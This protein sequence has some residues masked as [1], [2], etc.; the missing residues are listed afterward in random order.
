MLE[1]TARTP[2]STAPSTHGI[3]QVS[4]VDTA[5]PAATPT[6][7]DVALAYGAAGRSVLPI[8][9]GSKIPS[10]FNTTTGEFQELSWKKFQKRPAD[11]GMIQIMFTHSPLGIGIVCGP[12]S[13]VQIDGVQY[14]LEVTDFDDAEILDQFIEAANWQGLGELLRRLLH[15]RTPGGAG[16][17][18]YLC[19]QWAGNTKLAQRQEGVDEHGNP[20][21]VTL[22]ET[23][24]AGGQVV[25]APTPPGIHPEHP[26]RGYELVRGSWED[27]RIITPEERLVLF[28]LA[29]SFNEYVTPNQVHTTRDAGSPSTNGE[30]PGDTLNTTA[31]RDW[32]RN[33][34]ERHGWTLVR[35]RGDIQYWR[36]PGKD[37]K[38]W[39]ATLGACGPYF[40]VFSS[41]APPFEP[42]RGYLPFSAYTLLE[43]G[44]NFKAAAKALAPP[45]L[46]VSP[47]NSNSTTQAT[48]P[49]GDPAASLGTVSPCTHVANATRLAREYADRLHYV[50]GRGWILWTGQYW[51]TDPTAE[52]ALASGFV[53][54]LAHAIA[55]EASTL[56]EQAAQ[57]V[58][59]DRRTALMKLADARLK[60]AVQSENERVIAAGLKLA[61]RALLID[62]RATNT[63]PWLFNCENGTLNLRTGKLRDHNPEDLITHISPVTFDPDAT[64]PTWERFL[65]EVFADDMKMVRFIQRAIGWS[66]TGV[67]QERALFF[68]YGPKGH[69]G[70]TTL[71]EI[72]R[73]LLGDYGEASFGYAR[74]VDVS[75][76]VK[77][78]NQDDNQRKA[79][80]LA[81]PRFVYSSEVDAEHRL[82]EQLIKDI[83]GGD[84]LEGRHLYREPFTFKPAFKPWMYG[85]HKPE[86]RGTDDALWS[87]VKLVEFEVSF[88]DRVDPTLPETLRTELSGILNWTI[89]GCLDWQ[90]EGLNPPEKVKAATQQYRLEQ[91]RV[92]QFINE[93]CVVLPEASI[94]ATELFAAYCRWCAENGHEALT[95][96]KFGAY[97]TAHDFPSDGNAT[98]RGAIRRG[99]GLHATQRVAPQ[100]Q[101]VAKGSSAEA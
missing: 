39:S 47:G 9:P 63:D 59:K 70:K 41:N 35:Q 15:Q 90:R 5:T 29:R 27:P 88:A 7:R 19:Q 58:D 46:L 62:H 54:G 53:S 82:N 42:E 68:L 13:G 32:W 77:S 12:V 78:K 49:A 37:G 55:R 72:I 101:R 14:A 1:Y 26:E 44:G 18:G 30:R 87:R 6:I 66:L 22:I 74:K 71:V 83:T 40:Y 34:L 76:F 31:D 50:V 56:L 20:I 16:H 92:A 51:R 10:F 61:K 84:T 33:L 64:C 45:R 85:N 8:A 95:Q 98:G 43:H 36:R 69:N 96:N 73:D 86:I 24:G 28:E 48:L 17:F 67:V 21:V 3:Q 75:T 57:E 99:I 97:L 38:G 81:G 23:R 94:K 100:Q 2:R 4:R 65:S 91:D 93:C 52:G 80:M 79:A 89:K 60:W 25:V 11:Q